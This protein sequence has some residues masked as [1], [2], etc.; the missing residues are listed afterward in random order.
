MQT[1]FGSVKNRKASSPPSGP[2]P[3]AFMPPTL[4][5]ELVSG[6]KHLHFLS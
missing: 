1:F 2:T 4:P 3:L 5:D 6:V